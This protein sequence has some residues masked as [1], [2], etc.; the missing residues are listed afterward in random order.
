MPSNNNNN[1][2]TNTGNN[3][4]AG[5]SIQSHY[6]K[7]GEDQSYENSFF[8]SSEG[9]YIDDLCQKVARRFGLELRQQE[10][11]SVPSS[12]SIASPPPPLVLLDVGGGTGNFTNQILR[13]SNPLLEKAIV[14]DPF[15]T[16]KE[17]DKDTEPMSTGQER[18]G[19]LQF[20]QARAQEFTSPNQTWWKQNYHLVLMKE[21]VHHFDQSERVP[22]FRGIYNGMIASDTV[23]DN[24]LPPPSFL[25]ITRPH[26]D[27]DYPLWTE[28]QQV[29]AKNQP[30]ASVFENDL[31][32][33]G[34][35]DTQTTVET[36]PCSVELS[37]WQD[38]IQRRF[39]STFAHFSDSELEK[40][41]LQDIPTIHQHRIDQK[42]KLHFEDRLV[43]ISA[44]KGEP[45]QSS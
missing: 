14:I 17:H 21:V 24:R 15:L 1:N 6:A 4:N 31:C 34:F 13:N 45:M 36:Y 44:R 38:M 29:W 37:V 33:A 43:F 26:K 25:I 18:R 22:I 23:K 30:P 16:P 20:V 2:N 41:A 28:A 8:S 27:I 5:G 39:W 42:G 7:H 9:A 32:Q 11:G 3:K 35:V 19:K 12:D 40:A 10:S